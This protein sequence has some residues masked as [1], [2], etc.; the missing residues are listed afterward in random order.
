MMNLGDY[1]AIMD[2]QWAAGVTRPIIHG[3]AFQPPGS[4]WPGHDNFFGI[5]ADSWNFRTFPQ[6]SMWRPLTDYWA[7]GAEVLENGRPRED[8]AVYRD[9]FVT[10]AATAAGIATNAGVYQVDPE[11]PTPVLTSSAGDQIV[12]AAA[13]RPTPFFDGRPLEQAGYTY[14]FLAPGGA[15]APAA[16]GSGVLSPAGPAYKAI[17]VDE[18]AIPAA[19][20]EALASDAK[21]GLAVVFVG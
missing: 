18:R 11:S 20:A 16:S 13:M 14:E 5:V 2:K 19:A 9:G 1:K 21:G 12:S 3:Y 17:V 15:S 6:W 10:T 8:V 4:P 7:R